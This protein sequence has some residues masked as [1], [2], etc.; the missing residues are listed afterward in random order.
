MDCVAEH[1]RPAACDGE[2]ERG[3][4]ELA[5]GVGAGLVSCPVHPGEACLSAS[6]HAAA[7]VDETLRSPDERGEQV[8]GDDVHGK[9]AWAG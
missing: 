2:G 9:Y 5:V 4:E 6:V 1:V 8:G 7:E 3:D